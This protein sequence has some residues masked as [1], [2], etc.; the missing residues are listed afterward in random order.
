M[1]AKILYVDGKS[2]MHIYLLQSIIL[3]LTNKYNDRLLPLLR[4]YH[5]HTL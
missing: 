1:L 5:F 4:Q 2:D 3:L